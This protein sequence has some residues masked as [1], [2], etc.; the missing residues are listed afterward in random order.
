[1]R[2]LYIRP[3]SLTLSVGTVV[4]VLCQYLSADEGMWLFN[5]VPAERLQQQYQF[6]PNPAWLEHLQKSS[7]RFDN[8]AS[9]S[10]VSADGLALTNH[11]VG[12]DAL[13]KLCAAHPRGR[14]IMVLPARMHAR[15]SVAVLDEDSIID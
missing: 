10:F 6:T 8:G 9:G 14:C 3:A 1:M 13:Q 12:S 2:L 7:V 11:H 15:E 5:A 4:F